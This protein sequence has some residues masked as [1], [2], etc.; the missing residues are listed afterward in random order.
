MTLG[1]IAS[2]IAFTAYGGLL[3]L[4]SQKGLTDASQN[5]VFF[6]YILDMVLIQVS[7]FGVSTAQ[8][9]TTALFWYTLNIPLTSAQVI[10]YFFFIRSFLKLSQTRKLI[11]GSVLIWFSILAI[12]LVFHSSLFTSVYRDPASRMYLPEIG[13]I[14]GIL[15]IPTIAFLGTTLFELARNYKNQ[16]R[17][18][19]ARIQYLFLAI[20]IIWLGMAANVSPYLQPYAID[21]IAN[22]ISALLIAYAI[23]RYQLLE[24]NTVLRK[25][26]ET[27]ISIMIFGIGNTAVILLFTKITHMEIDVKNLLFTPTIAVVTTLIALVPLRNRIQKYL[28]LNLFTTT[29]DGY[30][31]IRRLSQTA[32]SILD[33]KKLSRTLLI[34]VVDTL[35][36]QWGMLLIKHNDGTYQPIAWERV[37]N[38]LLFTL[39]KNHPILNWISKDHTSI[40]MY[41]FSELPRQTTP[42]SEQLNILMLME[43]EFLP[44]KVRGELAGILWLGPKISGRPYSQDDKTNLITV[45]NN[46]ASTI[47][48]ARLYEELQDELRERKLMEAALRENEAIFSSFLKHSQVY[49]FFKDKDIRSLKLSKNYEQMLGIPISELLGKTMD[50]LFPSELAKRMI[51]DDQ[52]ILQEGKHVTVEEEFNGRVYETSKF[53]IFQSGEPI[54][55]AGITIDVTERKQADEKIQETNKL[56]KKRLDEIKTLQENL[57]DQVI[58]DPL[59][60]LFNRRYL[61]ETFDREL[62]RAKRDNYPL[63]VMMIDIDHFKDINDTYG[64]QVGDEALVSLGNL[65]Q[66]SIRQGDFACRYGGDEFIV[67]MPNIHEKDV[68]QRAETLR[69]EVKDI[70]INTGTKKVFMTASIGIALYP[71]HGDNLDQIMKA[72][73]DAMYEAKNSGRNRVSVWK[74]KK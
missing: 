8:N 46:I 68:E 40:T 52:K 43:S 58:R 1:I 29:Y 64:H 67:I 44:L 66:E 6:F 15:S 62:A 23:W 41:S 2:L 13:P 31:M 74:N 60:G 72:S 32:T 53:P 21:V 65:L 24:L 73:D 56:L 69:H 11:W 57:H 70:P 55:L 26:S 51:A 39:R 61:Y 18:Q 50:D 34:D 12:S 49:V 22:I 20:L 71:K 38:E 17:S 7:Y 30:E 54:M 63:S 4:V 35:Q 16:L 47:D 9:T 14:A 25:A 33:L 28:G 5:R 48:N 59:T 36:A 19:Q 27:F 37:D 3:L 45:A 42:V 10:I